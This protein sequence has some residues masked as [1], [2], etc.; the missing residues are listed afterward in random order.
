LD[1]LPITVLTMERISRFDFLDFLVN[2]CLEPA[3]KQFV[4]KSDESVNGT[5][6]I[7]YRLKV[8][9]S[10]NMIYGLRIVVSQ[11]GI[12]Q[13][14][15]NE[16]HFGYLKKEEFNSSYISEEQLLPSPRIYAKTE[17]VQ[18]TLGDSSQ[19]AIVVPKKIVKREDSIQAVKRSKNARYDFDWKPLSEE[20]KQKINLEEAK[21]KAEE[22]AK[23]I[24]KVL[25]R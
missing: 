20:S 16:I 11:S 9:Q 25:N 8:R 3:N 24:D 5:T 12:D 19:P 1:R 7:V 17:W 10:D 18:L 14:L 2:F 21:K 23:D 22:L 4:S 15:V 13:G 6:R